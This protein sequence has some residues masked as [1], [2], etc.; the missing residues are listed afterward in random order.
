[1]IKTNAIFFGKAL[2]EGLLLDDLLIVKNWMSDNGIAQ[3]LPA[4]VDYEGGAAVGF[5]DATAAEQIGYDLQ[6]VKDQVISLMTYNK[7]AKR[8]KIGVSVYGSLFIFGVTNN[9]GGATITACIDCL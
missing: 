2:D 1:M 9:F 3:V 5:I 4:D 6:C 8:C 7:F